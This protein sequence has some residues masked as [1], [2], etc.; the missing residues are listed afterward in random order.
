MEFPALALQAI[1]SDKEVLALLTNNPEIDLNSDE[2]DAVYDKYLFDYQYVDGTTE[3]AEAYVY[4][5]IEITGQPTDTMRNMNLYITIVC[6]KKYMKLDPAK[7]K[8]SIGNRRDNLVR[9]IDRL[10]N[11]STLFG[12]GKLRLDTIT[13]I[14]S[15][16]GFSAREITYK[17][18]D[19]QTKEIR[20]K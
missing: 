6:H 10:L 16:A 7:F 1:G 15:P 12:I 17:I 20:F 13:T 14:P 19:I 9:Y 11:G 3:E 2:A 5:E 4:A 8:G 18:P